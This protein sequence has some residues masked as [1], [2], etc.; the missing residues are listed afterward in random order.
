[1]ITQLFQK[2][3]LIDYKTFFEISSFFFFFF[4]TFLHCQ[5]SSL[6][7][8]AHDELMHWYVIFNAKYPC[9]VANAQHQIIFTLPQTFLK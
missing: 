4:F 7:S 8:C 1:M 6:V 5:I 3:V 2:N 9:S